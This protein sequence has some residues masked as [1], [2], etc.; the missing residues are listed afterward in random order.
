MRLSFIRARERAHSCDRVRTV[1][2]RAPRRPAFLSVRKIIPTHTCDS[3][4]FFLMLD[5]PNIMTN[6]KTRYVCRDSGSWA[7]ICIIMIINRNYRIST[8]FHRRC[9]HSFFFLFLHS[10][11]RASRCRFRLV[12]GEITDRWSTDTRRD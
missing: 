7:R 6:G 11:R 2:N 5:A 12:G 8:W 3:P 10:A 9:V 4:P 1:L